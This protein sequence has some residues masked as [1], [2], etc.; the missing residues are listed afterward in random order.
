MSMENPKDQNFL[1]HRNFRLRCLCNLFSFLCCKKNENSRKK[2][3]LH[4][5]TLTSGLLTQSE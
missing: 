3:P 5:F 4:S 2:V 1:T